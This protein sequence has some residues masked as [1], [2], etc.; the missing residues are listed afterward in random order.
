M[1]TSPIRVAVKKWTHPTKAEKAGAMVS[2]VRGL[3]ECV[4]GCERG[5]GKCRY[6]IGTCGKD[7]DEYH[8]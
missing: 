6:G 8:Y 2:Q 5:L 7:D 1:V 3:S 4:A